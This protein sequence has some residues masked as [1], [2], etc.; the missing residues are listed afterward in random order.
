VR[1][2]AAPI[3]NGLGEIIAGLSVAGPVYRINKSRINSYARLVMQ[4]A[5]KVSMQIGYEPIKPD[6]THELV[7]NH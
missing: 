7:R 5:Q 4:Y 6:R 1:A 3:F 2:V